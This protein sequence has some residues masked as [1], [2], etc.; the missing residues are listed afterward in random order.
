MTPSW[1]AVQLLERGWLPDPMIRAGIRRVVASRL[2][3]EERD[4]RGVPDAIAR[5]ARARSEGPIAMETRAANEQHYE[6]P[7][8]FYRLRA[9]PAR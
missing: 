1:L 9:R 7:T 3:E 4:S 8:E 6:V 2:R 5:F